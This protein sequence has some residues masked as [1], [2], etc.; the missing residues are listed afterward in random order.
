MTPRAHPSEARKLSNA[1]RSLPLGPV[2]PDQQKQFKTPWISQVPQL[3]ESAST[4]EKVVQGNAA[5]S[6]ESQILEKE[7]GDTLTKSVGTSSE[8][9]ATTPQEMGCADGENAGFDLNKTPQQKTPRRKHRPKVVVEG[10]PKRSPKPPAAPDGSLPAKRKYTRNNDTKNSTPPVTETV[11]V[12]EVSDT[13]PTAKSCKRKLNFDETVADNRAEKEGQGSRHDQQEQSN[14]LHKLREESSGASTSAANTY[15]REGQQTPPAYNFVQTT[16]NILPQESTP[17]E[18]AAMTPTSRDRSLNVLARTL[19]MRNARM[20]QFNSN[21]MYN[22]QVH[23]HSNLGFQSHPFEQNLGLRAKSSVQTTP[24]VLEDLVDVTDKQ[25]TKRAYNSTVTGNPQ[26][27]AFMGSQI[28]SPRT[29]EWRSG[30]ETF[31][32]KN[33]QDQSNGSSFSMHSGLTNVEILQRIEIMRSRGLLRQISTGTQNTE[34]RNSDCER[35]VVNF[36]PNENSTNFIYDRRM[37]YLNMRHKFQQQQ[38]QH[39]LSQGYQCSERMLPKTPQQFADTKITKSITA[40]VNW[41]ESP[42]MKVPQPIPIN[43]NTRSPP[44]HLAVK[45]RTYKKEPVV[46]KVLQQ[47]YEYRKRYENSPK[48]VVGNKSFCQLSCLYKR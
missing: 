21:S 28:Q 11:K 20:H 32:E 14:E 16:N 18:S 43:G 29:P 40:V 27:V 34:S 4:P 22:Q 13:G 45:K 3:M 42:S 33:I 48:K 26:N 36:N 24:Q 5:L 47:E 8:A 15:D 41:K 37:N 9:V 12:V 19:S 1:S 10:K 25:G 35:R 6:S 44:L 17:L 31:N 46:N 23:H 38:Q 39:A 7:H 30:S 2:T